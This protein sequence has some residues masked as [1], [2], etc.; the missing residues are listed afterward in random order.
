MMAILFLADKR[1][2]EPDVNLVYFGVAYT[3][4]LYQHANNVKPYS[5]SLFK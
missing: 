3:F 2:T 1:T 5:F 4:C